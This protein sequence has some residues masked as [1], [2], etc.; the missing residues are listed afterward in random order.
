MHKQHYV[1]LAVMAALS[2][3]AMY[4]LMYAM[5]NTFSNVYANFNQAYMSALMAAPMVIIELLVMKGMYENRKW[6]ALILAGSAVV[7]VGSFSLIRAQT[8]I[9]DAQFLRSMIPHHAGAILMCEQAPIEDA[10]IKALC[11]RIIA[12]QRAEIEAMKAKLDAL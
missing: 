12:S 7:L 1:R 6:N 9:S 3:V 4:V 11:T 5:V 10:D 8:G 2:F